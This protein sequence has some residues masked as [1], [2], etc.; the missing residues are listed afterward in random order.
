M[1]GLAGRPEI[2]S[3][4]EQGNGGIYRPRSRPSSPTTV[5]GVLS[6]PPTSAQPAVSSFINCS[7]SDRIVE[8]LRA[9]QGV[10]CLASRFGEAPLEAACARALAHD[11]PH[12]RPPALSSGPV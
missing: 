7:L 3:G 4:H 1:P 12:R 2:T 11:G 10:L 8:R 5:P 6:E 9:A